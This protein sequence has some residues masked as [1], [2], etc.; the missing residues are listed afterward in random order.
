MSEFKGA[1]RLAAALLRAYPPAWRTRYGEEFHQLL[2]DEL[3]D[4]RSSLG[5]WLNLVTHGVLARLTEWGIAGDVERDRRITVAMRI[6][7]LAVVLGGACGAAMWAQ[8]AVGWQ[9]SAPASSSTRTGIELITAG[10]AGLALSGGSLAAGSLMVA[11]RRGRFRQRDARIALAMFCGCAV[12]LALGAGWIGLSWPGTGGHYWTERGLAP[13]WLGR[14]MWA[15][16]L[17]LSTYWAH[18]DQ[19]RALGNGAGWLDVA[20]PGADCLACVHVAPSGRASWLCAAAAVDDGRGR[21][22]GC[23]FHVPRGH[24]RRGL[25]S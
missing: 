3:D 7:G 20:E 8:L 15:L 14:R 19:L 22:A 11:V 10:L 24:W 9:W 16:T 23:R 21:A 18:P 13:A 4:R 6:T 12:V 1:H 25:V 5:W 17:S 2:L